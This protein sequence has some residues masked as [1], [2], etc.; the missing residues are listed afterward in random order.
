MATEVRRYQTADR[1]T[2]LTDWLDEL[3]DGQTR[4][5][6]LACVDRLQAGLLGDWKNVGE[7]VCELRIDFGPGYRVY[8]GQEGKS[9][10]L[11]LCGGDKSTQ[12]KDIKRAHAYWKDYQARRTKPPVQ[13]GG[14]PAKRGR[15]RRVH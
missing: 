10:I 6:I 4:A 7:G 13:R 2:P 14:P 12:E 5:R 9:L 1:K 8:Y 11:L 15:N 3:R